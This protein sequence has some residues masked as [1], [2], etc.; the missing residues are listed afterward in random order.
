MGRKAHSGY[1]VGHVGSPYRAS[2]TE[3]RVRGLRAPNPA[4]RLPSFRGG[5]C[6]Q[7]KLISSISLT[8]RLTLLRQTTLSGATVG[9]GSDS[10]TLVNLSRA[11]ARSSREPSPTLCFGEGAEAQSIRK[12]ANARRMRG[13]KKR[14]KAS[15]RYTLILSVPLTAPGSRIAAKA[16]HRASHPLRGNRRGRFGLA[17]RS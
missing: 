13:S 16:A 4:L 17:Y 2:P 7:Y 15:R 10:L 6:G 1:A 11:N 12:N 14:N 3:E 8:V 5:K 9:V